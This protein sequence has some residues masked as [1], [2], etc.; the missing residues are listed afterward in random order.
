MLTLKQA[1]QLAT[2]AHE[3][4]EIHEGHFMEFIKYMNKKDRQ[5]ALYKVS[6]KL[7]KLCDTTYNHLTKNGIMY[8]QKELDNF[9]NFKAL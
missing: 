6:S 3:I 8:T 5:F 2:E 1:I 9:F 4:H 7:F